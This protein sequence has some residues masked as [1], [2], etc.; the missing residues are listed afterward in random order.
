[1]RVTHAGV[2]K[3]VEHSQS[4]ERA[5]SGANQRY[6]EVWVGRQR[7]GKTTALRARARA[8]AADPAV[9]SVWILDRT[10]EWPGRF[11]YEF[12]R[13][14]SVA[15]Y[16]AD[17]DPDLP[18]VIVWQCGHDPAAYDEVWTEAIEVGNVAIIA[19][20][21]YQFAP[22]GPKFSGSPDL[23]RICL[24]GRHLQNAEGEHCVT[25]LVLALQYPRTMH[26]LLWS[27]AEEVYCGL[28]MGEQSRT[29]VKHAFDRSDFAA[30][31]AVD[32]VDRYDFVPL[33]EPEKGLPDLPGY[34]PRG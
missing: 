27:Q 5:V 33:I 8:L 19:D 15:D 7:S 22:A 10:N 34:G 16:L 3:G 2:I 31:D 17:E 6:Y 30:L 26:H 9:S 12:T 21:C 28:I 18:R 23:E 14:A 32:Q 24:S 11:E 13:Y 4:G 20:E 25:H 1:M 29:W